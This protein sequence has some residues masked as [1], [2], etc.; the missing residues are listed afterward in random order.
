MIIPNFSELEIVN[1]SN[2][3]VANSEY[4]AIHVRQTVNLAQFCVLAGTGASSGGFQPFRDYMYWFG[5]GF[6]HPGDWIF[7]FTG[8][9]EP[10]KQESPDGAA[11]Y[12]STYWGKP[13]TIFAQSNVVPA[14]S[15]IGAINIFPELT[16][17]PQYSQVEKKD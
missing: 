9:G 15:K 11:M 12:Y 14:I 4:V 17:Q 5:E 7:L 6:V 3:G 16:D 13:H 1:V 8:S 10:S 2:R